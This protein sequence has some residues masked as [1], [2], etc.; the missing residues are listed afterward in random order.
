MAGTSL[1]VYP[2]HDV[3]IHTDLRVCGDR[4]IGPGG[5]LIHSTSGTDSLAWLQGGSA[6]AGSPASADALIARQGTQY[7]ITPDGKYAY[8]AGPS[9]FTLDRSYYGDEVSQFFLGIELEC[10][11]TQIP[12]FEQYDSLADLLVYYAG[13]HAWRWPLIILGHYAV[14]RP[15]GRRSDPVNFDWGWLLGRLYVR[16][17]AVQLPGLV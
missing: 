6:N 10:L 3:T 4:T 15:L 16:A 13:I 5:A 14:A 17:L 7:L 1:N 9:F 8:H 11:D 12:T 2:R